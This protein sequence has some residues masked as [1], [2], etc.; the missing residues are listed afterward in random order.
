MNRELYSSS[1]LYREGYDD[2]VKE[3]KKQVLDELSV[4]MRCLNT[5]FIS[6]IKEM[7]E[8][9]LTERDKLYLQSDEAAVQDVLREQFKL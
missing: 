9:G 1:F 2:G 7:T 3:G 5:C 8:G 6:L 4:H